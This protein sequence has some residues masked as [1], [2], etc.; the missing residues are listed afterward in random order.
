MV[1]H[2]LAWQRHRLAG[3]AS[4]GL[5]QRV[6]AGCAVGQPAVELVRQGHAVG[7]DDKALRGVSGD[8]A[9][10]AAYLAGKQAGPQPFDR[11][12]CA[13]VLTGLGPGWTDGGDA[14]P[15]GVGLLAVGVL[16][17]RRVGGQPF[18]LAGQRTT[19]ALLSALGKGPSCLGRS[20]RTFG[21]VVYCR[22]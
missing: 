6:G 8:A 7:R 22:V 11:G 21:Q 13:Q 12:Q 16:Q 9:Q 15:Q 1:A 19:P 4:Q 20:Q 14:G 10:G 5:G 3:L 17:L 18:G 2:Q